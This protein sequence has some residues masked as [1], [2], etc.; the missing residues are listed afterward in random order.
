MA[1]EDSISL[2]TSQIDQSRITKRENVEAEE[3]D[4]EDQHFSDQFYG[5]AI[6]IKNPTVT[7]R[8]RMMEY[9]CAGCKSRLTSVES[10]NKHVENCKYTAVLKYMEIFRSLCEQ[11]RSDRL[12]E[13]ELIVHGIK[14]ISLAHEELHKTAK[15]IKIPLSYVS[16]VP[17]TDGDYSKIPMNYSRRPTKFSPDQGYTS[18]PH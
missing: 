12:T 7:H 2:E 16:P 9:N 17:P 11:K 1:N 13:R 10:Y 4:L 18:S 5:A 15:N 6:Q 3:E 14:Q 8:K